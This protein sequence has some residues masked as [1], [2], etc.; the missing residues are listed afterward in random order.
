MI[1]GY[2]PMMLKFA[3]EK[4]ARKLASELLTNPRLQQLGTKS[5]EA[6]NQHKYGILTKLSHLFAQEIKKTSPEMAQ[7][8]DSLSEDEFKNMLSRYSK[9]P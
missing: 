4:T 9:H 5:A 6:I 2:Y 7:E 1:T 8:I 3:G